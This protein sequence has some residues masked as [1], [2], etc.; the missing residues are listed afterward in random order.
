[1]RMSTLFLTHEI[2]KLVDLN[3]GRPTATGDQE[4]LWDKRNNEAPTSLYMCMNYQK[5]ESVSGCKSGYEIWTKLNT[6]YESITGASRQVLLQK[7]DSIMETRGE[8]NA[9]LSS[10]RHE[11]AEL[12]RTFLESSLSEPSFS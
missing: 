9:Q 8:P 5:V 1:M 3:E 11:R 6:I 10:A 7:Y 12:S 4:D 2:M